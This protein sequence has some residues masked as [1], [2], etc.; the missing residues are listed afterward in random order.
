MWVYFNVPE[1]EYLDYTV[2]L[3][4]DEPLNV[5][6]LMANNKLFQYL[7]VVETIEADFNSETGNIP[8]RATFPNPEGLL[9]HGETG[10]IK[11][12]VSLKNALVIPQKTT[13]EI[14]DK[15]YVYVVDEKNILHSRQ[16]TVG[17][18]MQHL[19]VVTGGL[20]PT[21]KILLDGLRKVKEKEEIKYDYLKPDAVLSK[22]ELY[23]E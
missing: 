9:R 8:F 18:E 23:A 12:K 1:A 16:I 3:K 10:N 14:L 22:L 19:Y 15:K 2:Q 4:K 20:K 11:L 17:E 6:L 13:F 7:G 21:D 5:E